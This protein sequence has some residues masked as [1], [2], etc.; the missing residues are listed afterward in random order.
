MTQAI[1]KITVKA[2]GV[3]YFTLSEGRAMFQAPESPTEI[4]ANG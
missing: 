3:Q 4:Q 2:K 1:I